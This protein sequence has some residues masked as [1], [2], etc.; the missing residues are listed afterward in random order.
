MGILTGGKEMKKI[1]VKKLQIF[2]LYIALSIGAFLMIFP[3]LWGIFTSFKTMSEIMHTPPTFWPKNPTLKNYNEVLKT[4]P[5]VQYYLNSLLVTS[6]TTLS[7]LFTGSLT[8]YIFAKFEFLGKKV[9]FTLILASMMIPFAV[10]MVPLYI[11]L[12]FFGLIDSYGALIIPLLTTPFSIFLICQYIK[13]SITTE[14]LEA[15]RIDGCSEFGIYLRIIIPQIKP[16]LAALAIFNFMSV[17]NLYIWPLVA[18]N[19]TELRTLPVGIAMLRGQYQT[20]WD[21]ISAAT[22]LAVVPALI[23]FF[24]LQ[25]QFVEGITLTGIKG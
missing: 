7:V 17:W 12:N 4:I 24:I 19:S 2:I 21:L 18:V 25:K 11:T 15:S 22:V 23:M 5:I 6:I 13:G 9:L 8:G 20:R 16:A 14:M 10:T 3:F 1:N